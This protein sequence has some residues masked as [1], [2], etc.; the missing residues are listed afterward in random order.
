M[1]DVETTYDFGSKYTQASLPERAVLYNFF[2][3]VGALTR[4]LNV[5]NALEVGCGEGHSTH[6]LR[7]LLPPGAGFRACD[8]GRRLVE[9][10][11]AAIRRLGG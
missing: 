10:A 5:Q 4:P 3:T 1:T 11:R 7:H 2:R 9:A 6:R 8:V